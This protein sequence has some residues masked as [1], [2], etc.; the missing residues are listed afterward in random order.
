MQLPNDPL[1]SQQWYLY[2]TGQGG[3]TPRVDLNLIDE[4]P[5]TFNVWDEYSG[6]GVQVGILDDG[7]Q[8]HHEDLWSNY[9]STPKGISYTLGEGLPRHFRH[10]HG[11][12]V[13]GIIAGAKNGIGIVGIAFNANITGFYFGDILA[14]QDMTRLEQQ[15][16]FDISNNS[17]GFSHPFYINSLNPYGQVFQ[18]ALEKGIRQGR[19]GIGTIFVW[20]GGNS[21]SELGYESNYNNEK[22]SRYT[23][24]VAAIDGHGVGAPYSSQGANLLVSAFGDGDFYGNPPSIVTTDLMGLGG[25]N[26]PG[27][28]QFP[29]SLNLNYTSTFNGTSAAAPM[30]SGVVALM[31]EANPYLGYRDVQQILAYSARQNNSTHEDW[32]FNGA[33]NWN[34]G[35]L[36]VNHDYGFGLVDAHGAVRL[37][38]SWTFQ[39]GWIGK[40]A[41]STWVNEK[42]FEGLSSLGRVIPKAETISDT[43][44]LPAGIE[45]ESAE[46]RVTVSHEAIEDLVIRLTSPGGT[47]SILFDGSRLN[48][49]KLGK[50]GRV[51]FSEFRDNPSLFTD[52]S[53]LQELGESYQQGIDFTFSSTFNWGESSE[54]DWIL[55]L[56]N[57]GMNHDGQLKDWGLNVYGSEDSGNRAYIYTEEYGALTDPERQYLENRQGQHLLNATAMRSD[58]RIDLTRQS[59]SILAGQPLTLDADTQ[60]VAVFGGDGNDMIWGNPDQSTYLMNRRGNNLMV[61]GN[62]NDII[63]G[64]VGNDILSGGAGDD[65]LSGGAGDDILFG[66]AGDNT[67]FGGAGDDLLVGGQGNDILS[68]DFGNDTLIGGGGNNIF[69]LRPDGGQNV[70]DDFTVGSDRLGLSH[71]LTFDALTFEQSGTDTLIRQGD[72]TWTIV[73]NVDSASLTPESFL[74]IRFV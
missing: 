15:S 9:N 63:Q 60:I 23:I 40:P 7:V 51:D 10:A 44:I 70:I 52:D 34:G 73:S 54:G 1:F 41:Q 59:D 35:G 43:I 50:N 5:N 72:Q 22:N 58:S 62:G 21:R 65:I 74:E 48:T 14:F 30:V 24:A 45:L 19:D 13:A 18:Q 12:A 3:R 67:L 69:V 47:E 32:Q 39:N 57:L 37:A 55:T 42:S 68:G 53:F 64:G 4:N 28:S 56:E 25:S 29:E 49:L 31:L 16:A 2:N 27:I 17:W 36:H 71:G 33:R 8:F 46:I 66:G 20:G 11:T 26:A 38:E 6:K 61:G